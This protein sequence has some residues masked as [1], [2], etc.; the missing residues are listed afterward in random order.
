M[1]VVDFET[2]RTWIGERLDDVVGAK[3]GTV[4]GLYLDSETREALWLIVRLGRQEQYAAVPLDEASE[5]G[6]RV[7]VPYERE[8]VRS[9]RRLLP[10]LPLAPGHE[11][12]LCEHYGVGMTRGAMA[13][14]WER[15]TCAFA[16]GDIEDPGVREAVD[17]TRWAGLERRGRI[18]DPAVGAAVAA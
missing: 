9:S 11:R 14:G 16:V 3:V 5:G 18:T 17:A 7:W 1:P 12:D 2:A 13:A 10:G 8:R 4:K 15:R 6:G